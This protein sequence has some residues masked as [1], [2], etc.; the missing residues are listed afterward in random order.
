[1]YNVAEDKKDRRN[2]GHQNNEL[3]TSY[4]RTVTDCVN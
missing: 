4:A 2:A 3:V 1:M